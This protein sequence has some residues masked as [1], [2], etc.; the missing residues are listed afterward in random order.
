MSATD[1]TALN[2]RRSRS[3]S[4]AFGGERPAMRRAVSVAGPGRPPHTRTPARGAFPRGDRAGARAGVERVLGGGGLGT[5]AP[6]ASSPAPRRGRHAR[7]LLRVQELHAHRDRA[8]RRR[9]RGPGCATP[10]SSRAP[11]P[12]PPGAARARPLSLSSRPRGTR[13]RAASTA[14]APTPRAR[15]AAISTTVRVD[16]SDDPSRRRCA[17]PRRSAAARLPPPRRVRPDRRRARRTAGAIPSARNLAP[18]AASRD[19]VSALLRAAILRRAPRRRRRWCGARARFDLTASGVDL[20]RAAPP[21]RPRRRAERDAGRRR[22]RASP[23][24]LRRH[25]FLAL[26]SRFSRDERRIRGEEAGVR[27]AAKTPRR[28]RRRRSA[29]AAFGSAPPRG[30]VASRGRGRSLLCLLPRHTSFVFAVSTVLEFGLRAQGHE[31]PPG[32]ARRR[33]PITASRAAALLGQTSSSARWLPRHRLALSPRVR[34]PSAAARESRRPMRR[35]AVLPRRSAVARYARGPAGPS[36]QVVAAARLGLR[37]G[38]RRAGSATCMY[39][40]TYSRGRRHTRVP[41]RAACARRI[42]R[43]A[44]DL[45]PRGVRTFL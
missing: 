27:S 10:P 11:S 26:S 3:S 44:L 38:R 23:S 30:D 1:A 36:T 12:L 42:L 41:C 37:V 35:S 2:D 28:R 5:A 15:A 31:A 34:R 8:R 19:A 21:R 43:T 24:R 9:R 22:L 40:H 18:S 33:S 7:V 20:R 39:Y 6:L 14:A 16:V 32:E 17:A 13:A 25:A 29:A 4:T 45:S